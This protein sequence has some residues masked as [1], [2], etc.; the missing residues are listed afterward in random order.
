MSNTASCLVVVG[1]IY[2]L[3]FGI[4]HLSFWKLFNWGEELSHMS[5]INR[6]V[7]QMLNVAV[8]VFLFMMACVSMVYSDEMVTTGLGKTLLLG[9]SIFWI[10]RLIGEFTLKNGTQINPKLVIIFL[11]G[12][13]LH[14]LPMFIL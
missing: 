10:T 12:I 3:L 1:G 11:I 5:P 6:A 9:I 8:I 2:N 14:I 7:M 13:F 4:F